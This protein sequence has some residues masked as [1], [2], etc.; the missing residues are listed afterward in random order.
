MFQRTLDFCNRLLVSEHFQVIQNHHLSFGIDGRN[1][2]CDKLDFF[3]T[4]S[5]SIN[6]CNQSNSSLCSIPIVIVFILYSI[7]ELGVNA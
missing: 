4:H 6:S 7:A 1:I 5:F 2:G 3:N